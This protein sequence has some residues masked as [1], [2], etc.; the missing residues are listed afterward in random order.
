MKKIRKGLQPLKYKFPFVASDSFNVVYFYWKC[1]SKG[2]GYWWVRPEDVI[3]RC[4]VNWHGDLIGHAD[5]LKEAERIIYNHYITNKHEK[6]SH[7][8]RN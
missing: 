4:E 1:N 5:T 6:K 7:A 8:K 2:S 3:L